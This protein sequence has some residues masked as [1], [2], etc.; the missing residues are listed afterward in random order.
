[1]TDPQNPWQNPDQWQQT[2]AQTPTQWENPATSQYQ[3]MPMH[4]PAWSMAPL[5]PVLPQEM[6]PPRP[7][8]ITAAMWIWIVA[9]V[10][11]VAVIPVLILG[12]LEEIRATES[13]ASDQDAAELGGQV[14]AVMSG[15]GMLVAAAPYIAFAVVL[16]NGRSWA[17]ILLTILGGLG[18]M[19][20]L[21]TMLIGVQAQVW[22]LGVALTI[23][24]M[25]LTVAA[26]VLQFLPASNRYVR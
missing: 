18:L 17:R 26:L 11:A 9:A 10:I 19:A 6:A 22:Q 21:V 25:G 16:R 7:A 15:F 5:S 4:N 1:M 8:T 14:I 2:P 20:M 13:T 3:V 12:N 23:V 24:V